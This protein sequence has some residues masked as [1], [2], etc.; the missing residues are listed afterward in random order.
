MLIHFD[1]YVFSW[2]Y[3]MHKQTVFADASKG[4]PLW[5]GMEDYPA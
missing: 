3:L 4:V 2:I 1:F 5:E